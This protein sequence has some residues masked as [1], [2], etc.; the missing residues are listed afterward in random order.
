MAHAVKSRKNAKCTIESS[1]NGFITVSV[2]LPLTIKR[3]KQG[4]R[5]IVITSKEKASALKERRTVSDIVA[6]GPIKSINSGK[7]IIDTTKSPI[8]SKDAQALAISQQN[9]VIIK[10][11]SRRS[12]FLKRTVTQRIFRQAKFGSRVYAT[13]ETGEI[14]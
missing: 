4:D 12:I 5:V 6:Q 1:L 8:V 2:P 7:I 13:D 10:P 9:P 3:Y 11:L 14:K